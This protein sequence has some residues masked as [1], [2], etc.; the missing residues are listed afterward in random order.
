MYSQANCGRAALMSWAGSRATMHLMAGA[1][2]EAAINKLYHYEAFCP[3]YLTDTLVNQ[4]VHVSDPRNF[5]DPWDCCPYFDTTQ[6]SDPNYR[7]RCIQYIQQQVPLPN[8]TVAR[9][10]D[11]ESM[12]QASSRLFSEMLQTSFR[13]TLRD[14]LV[15]RWRI[16]C[17]T[18]HPAMSL[19]WSHYANHHQGICLEFDASQ[20][21]IGG[22]FQVKYSE[23]LPLLDILALS[24]E[25]AFQVLVTKSSDWA[26]ESE[27]R[28]LARDSKADDDSQFQP[29][30]TNDF[31]YLPPGAL[32]AIIAGCRADACAIKML[33]HKHAPGLP[34]KRAV[35][36]PERYSLSIQD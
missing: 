4:R 1:A 14:T 10:L 30:T 34:V 27:Y 5:N 8:I 13:K 18:V 7:A 36:A 20:A 21:V 6:A 19:M 15:N 33:V 16:Y 3:S 32:T 24:D 2:T 29:I 23:T 9:R 35:Q 22:A 12:L 25:A 26:Y 28:I 11:Y 31:L 17:L